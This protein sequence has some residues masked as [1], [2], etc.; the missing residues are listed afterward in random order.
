MV[1]PTFVELR[2]DAILAGYAVQ[3]PLL[4]VKRTSPGRASISAYDPNRTCWAVLR[5]LTK[6]DQPLYLSRPV[7][8]GGCSKI[9]ELGS[10][11]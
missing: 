6:L 10:D 9:C 5:S 3:C 7:P 2:P 8:F 11:G 1:A 4:G